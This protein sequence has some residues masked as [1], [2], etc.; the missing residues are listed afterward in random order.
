MM[1]GMFDEEEDYDYDDSSFEPAAY[2][3]R[4]LPP[5]PA[6]PRNDTDL[7]G[8]DNQGATCYM[9][10]LL[11]VLHM[12]PELRRGARRS[13]QAV[14]KKMAAPPPRR[15]PPPQPRPILTGARRRHRAPQVSTT[16]LPQSSACRTP[17]TASSR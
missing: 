16:C 5:R 17:T 13:R 1:G 9:N 10:S 8:L 11:Q 15:P 6:D 12:T 4:Q 7:C 2:S 14:R 3:G